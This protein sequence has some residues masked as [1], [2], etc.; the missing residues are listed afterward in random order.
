M[1]DRLELR[2]FGLKKAMIVTSAHIRVWKRRRKI[3]TYIVLEE[4]KHCR[5][6]TASGG[7]SCGGVKGRW[8]RVDDDE[9]PRNLL[10]AGL[11]KKAQLLNGLFFK[12]RTAEKISGTFV[13]PRWATW[14]ACQLLHPLD[15]S[16]LEPA[17]MQ[18]PTSMGNRGACLPVWSPHQAKTFWRW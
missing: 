9:L 8:K 10:W 13:G 6:Q 5:R 17:V 3:I 18:A 11:Y 14:P 12:T 4:S 15:W 16:V 1:R 7:G 2:E